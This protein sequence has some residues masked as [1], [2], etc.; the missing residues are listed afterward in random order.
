MFGGV[1]IGF[2]LGLVFRG[3]GSTG[4]TALL[5]AIMHKYTGLT[6][7]IS[8]LLIDGLIVLSSAIAFNIE[9]ALYAMISV[10]ITGKTIDIVQVG[11][12]HAKMALIISNEEELI[13]EAILKDLDRGVTKLK[14]QGGYT[15]DKRH[16]L[17]CVVNQNEVTK[18]KELV[19]YIDNEA[20][21]VVTYANEVLGEGFKREEKM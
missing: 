13:R 17:M 3:K 9:L 2:G 21:I 11:L 19:N 12:G 15:D 18:L 20:F 7:G 16:V 8:L 10:Y 14:A 6:L 5:A 4:G 1:G